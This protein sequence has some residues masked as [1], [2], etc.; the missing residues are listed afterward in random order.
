[1]PKRKYKLVYSVPGS[2]P[3]LHSLRYEVIKARNGK[4]ANVIGK[5]RAREVGGDYLST[6][7]LS[8]N[9]AA[10]RDFRKA[11]RYHNP[12]R[13][14]PF[15]LKHRHKGRPIKGIRNCPQP[16]KLAMTSRTVDLD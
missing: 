16:K 4:E 8:F 5:D 7:S 10:S 2:H 1:M 15:D 6:F 3:K 11:M 14:V 9:G 13:F 12:E